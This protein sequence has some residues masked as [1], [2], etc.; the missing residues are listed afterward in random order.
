MVLADSFAHSF[1]PPLRQNL[2]IEEVIIDSTA[3]WV[4]VEKKDST[5]DDEGSCNAFNTCRLL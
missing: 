3:S 4:A 5:K 1:L 2:D